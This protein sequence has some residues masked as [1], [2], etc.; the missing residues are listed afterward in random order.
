MV[1]I[2]RS[3]AHGARVWL[4][5]IVLASCVACAGPLRETD[6]PTSAANQAAPAPAVPTARLAPPAAQAPAPDCTPT[7]EQPPAG[8]LLALI[9]RVRG[10]PDLLLVAV[11]GGR[12]YAV[13]L[14]SLDLDPA[15]VAALPEREREEA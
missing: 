1:P 12:I 10:C 2:A 7:A 5:I 3:S 6:D 13:P 15:L 4:C 14:T 11:P 8:E 9:A